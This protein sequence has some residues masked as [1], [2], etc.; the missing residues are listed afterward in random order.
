MSLDLNGK[1]PQRG[2]V[3]W[4]APILGHE[5]IYGTK[6]N[7]SD[8]AEFLHPLDPEH[9][10]AACAWFST[11]LYEGDEEAVVYARAKKWL[12]PADRHGKLDR[13]LK[14][15]THP[16]V[17]PR[18]FGEHH[19]MTLARQT[20]LHC[21]G[22]VRYGDDGWKKRVSSAL[23]ITNDICAQPA[24]IDPRQLSGIS[25]PGNRWLFFRSML[26]QS[27][28]SRHQMYAHIVARASL[29][30]GELTRR[31][32][33][34]PE[35]ID[36]DAACL[37][38][39]GLTFD[40]LLMFGLFLGAALKKQSGPN[41][42]LTPAALLNMVGLPADAARRAMSFFVQTQD[43]AARRERE[44]VTQRGVFEPFDHIVL[45]Q[46]PIVQFEDRLLAPSYKLL[47]ERTTSGLYYVL[48]DAVSPEHRANQRFFN[49][50]GKLFHSYCDELL[51]LAGRTVGASY[52]PCPVV[53][54]RKQPDGEWSEG[55]DVVLF[56][57]KGGMFN[58]DAGVA[59]QDEMLRKCIDRVLIEAV[60]QLAAGVCAARARRNG[61]GRI[62][63]VIV[64]QYSMV[65]N[66][67]LMSVLHDRMKELGKSM[68][69]FRDVPPLILHISELERL[70]P[71][72]NKSGWSL[73]RLLSRWAEV[74]AE[75]LHNF[76][77]AE[78]MNG[79]NEMNPWL[80][81][82]AEQNS[83]RWSKRLGSA[84]PSAA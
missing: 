53:T 11:Q 76:L 60:D 59:A 72:L 70:E 15:L 55:D 1:G 78:K 40:E 29:M 36:F 69:A 58:F 23:L 45:Q 57:F 48:L 24:G 80:R 17:A 18:L 16:D 21:Q 33:A 20:L 31:H 19:L 12:I 6:L 27:V 64:T 49:F 30:F 75:N 37:T 26:P 61:R 43:V 32:S 39:M 67:L 9:V 47:M 56:E 79:W 46:H 10:L 77:Y 82:V 51:S 52:I 7:W 2:R 41:P 66:W 28:L 68:E 83:A 13:H 42:G 22:T 50:V 62:Y 34:D 38:T 81:T 3:P 65:A 14:Q 25:T 84:F 35:Y 4:M 44:R 8:V 71:V 73:S 54:G 5:G 63:A 74:P